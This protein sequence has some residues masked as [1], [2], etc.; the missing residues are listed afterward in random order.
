MLE[1]GTITISWKMLVSV[2]AVVVAGIAWEIGGGRGPWRNVGLWLAAG[3]GAFLALCIVV[4]LVLG[5]VGALG[6][7]A[8]WVMLG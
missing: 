5:A 7:W 1:I 4:G 2:W 8:Q 6:L 3:T